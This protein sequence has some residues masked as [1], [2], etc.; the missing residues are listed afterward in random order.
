[1]HLQ[2][3]MSFITLCGG[4][5]PFEIELHTLPVRSTLIKIFLGWL[6]RNKEE[7]QQSYRR[8]TV[9]KKATEGLEAL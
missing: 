6:L 1:M 3:S 2:R 9:S 8:E 7:L 4:L 5:L